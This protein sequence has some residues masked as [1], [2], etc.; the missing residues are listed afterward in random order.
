MY[1]QRREAIGN[2]D[3]KVDAARVGQGMLAQLLGRVFVQAPAQVGTLQVTVA[4]GSG[5]VQHQAVAAALA[6]LRA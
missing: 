1:G 2:H 3:G 5:A 6:E 4:I